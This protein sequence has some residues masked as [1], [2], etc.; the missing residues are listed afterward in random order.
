MQKSKLT[1][2]A[3]IY[4]PYLDTIGGGERYAMTLAEAL[5]KKGWQVDIFW[6][7]SGVKENLIKKFSLDIDRVN[8]VSYSPRINNLFKK[9]YFERTY[10]LLFYFSD[11][12]VPLMF[13]KRNLL[14]FQVPFQ[15]VKGRKFTNKLKFKFIDKIICNS[16]FTKQVIDKEYGVKG[17]IWYPPVDVEE[18]SPGK[19]E[20]Y[21]LA[22]GRFEKSMTEKRQDI[23]IDVFKRVIDGGLKGWKLILSGGCLDE[24]TSLLSDLKKTAESFPIEFKVNISFDELKKLYGGAKIF[25]HAAGFGIDE[26]EFPEKVEHFGITTVEAMAA[27]AVPVVIAKGGQKEIIEDKKN[28]FLWLEKDELSRITL[29][30][31]NNGDKLKE[32]S[33]KSIIR[34]SFFSK[35]VFYQRISCFI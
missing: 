16:N 7:D 32:V 1:K 33:K 35:E 5:L 17:D 30:L 11:G 12:S 25:W 19:K 24:S 31:A 14:H 27:G 8:F 6:R 21:I 3:G 34:S 9:I 2:K 26:K 23:L 18:F 22:V 28:G 4:D 29:D 10:D 15:G 20:N 13:G